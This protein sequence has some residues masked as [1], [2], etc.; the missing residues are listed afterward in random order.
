MRKLKRRMKIHWR[1]RKKDRSKMQR[2]MGYLASHYAL[3][4][5]FFYT[6]WAKVAGK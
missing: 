3:S 1:M 4:W 6:E 2:F 5:S